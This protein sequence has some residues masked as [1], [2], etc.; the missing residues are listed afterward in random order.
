MI[1]QVIPLEYASAEEVRNL[2]TPLI[3]KDGTIIAYKPTN[4]LIVT[5]RASNIYRFLKI[6]E[7]IDVRIIEEKISVFPLEFAS[8]RTLA[9]KLTQLRPPGAAS[10]GSPGKAD[11]PDHLPADCQGHPG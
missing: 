11:R 5:E 7:Q 3:S 10:A 9:D 1:T 8:A 2:F 4:H 6:I